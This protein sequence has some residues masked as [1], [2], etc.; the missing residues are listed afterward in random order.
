MITQPQPTAYTPRRWSQ[1]FAFATGN[2]TCLTSCHCEAPLVTATSRNASGTSAMSLTTNGSK[3]TK[4]AMNR[5]PIFCVSVVPNQ[6]I[7]SGINTT[8]GT[9]DPANARGRKKLAIDENVAM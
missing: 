4:Q 6:T 2:K 1:M 8:I 9:Y 7:V 3:A 5:N